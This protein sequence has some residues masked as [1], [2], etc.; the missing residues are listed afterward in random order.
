MFTSRRGLIRGAAASVAFAGLAKFA[1]AQVLTAEALE[2]DPYTS[3]VIGYG[4]LKRDPQGLVDLPEGFSYD[5]VSKAGDPMSDGLLT[6]YKMDGMGCFPMDE[7]RVILVRNHELKPLDLDW[8]A[9]GP[10]RALA[11]KMP[12]DRVYDHDDT[13]LPMGG[14]TTTLVYDLK[15]R[16][17]VRHHL[18]LTG[19]T[20]NCA[21][22][23]TPWG[24][25]LSCEET[26]QNRGQEAQKD[27]GWIFEVPSGLKGVADPAPIRGMGRFRHEAACVD[28]RTGVVYMTEDMGD[29]FGLFYRY[30]PNDRT[31][32]QAGGRLQALALPEG[33]DADP[34]NWD[35]AI[36]WQASDWRDAHWVDLDG[37]DNPYEDLRYR[38]HAK[39]AAWFARGDGV[40]FGGGELYFACTS[41]G[42]T[43][44]GQ[45]FRYV[46][47]PREG[48]VGEADEPGRLQL[49]VEP[50]DTRLLEMGDN[51][52]TSPWGHLFVCED[53]VGGSVN[54]LRAV[55]PDGRIYT[56]GR[57]AK[58]GAGDVAANSE[59]AGICFSPDGSTL[60]VNVYFPGMTLAITGPWA[61]FR[62]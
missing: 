18:S 45:I 28:P 27:H 21:G 14:G 7:R 50:H 32:L 17:V 54:Y 40:H 48:G 56:L 9:Y 1:A 11:G 43:G 36:Y 47:S 6:P 31:R 52:S 59:L 34:R 5:V 19:T 46:P 58:V 16:A 61:S 44:A 22:G 29:G 38:G 37:V 4:P 55:T 13:G 8:T 41:G 42:P 20:I 30:L 3:Q 53:K 35:S 15:T 23:V 24:S 51:I 2:A 62:A 57:N 33:G 25:W 26:T 39:G 49:F 12:R 60:F 10:G